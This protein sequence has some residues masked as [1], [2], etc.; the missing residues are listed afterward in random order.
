M[1]QNLLHILAMSCSGRF[2]YFTVSR[3]SLD[4]D[5]LCPNLSELLSLED[6]KAND[7]NTRL[8][9]STGDSFFHRQQQSCA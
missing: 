9:D 4:I 2:K 5:A 3:Q 7:M 1:D 8:K 6:P